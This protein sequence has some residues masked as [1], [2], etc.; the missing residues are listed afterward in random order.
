MGFR[1]AQAFIGAGVEGRKTVPSSTR[2]VSYPFGRGSDA[3]T[4]TPAGLASYSHALV[5]ITHEI[6]ISCTGARG[7]ALEALG[8]VRENRD[9][10]VATDRVRACIRPASVPSLCDWR[11]RHSSASGA[12]YP[13]CSNLWNRERPSCAV[14]ECDTAAG[15]YATLRAPRMDL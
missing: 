14:M 6:R 9:A 7:S 10:R 8:R 4:C 2:E 15:Y 11:H 3:I 13:R 1:M 12:G 5:C